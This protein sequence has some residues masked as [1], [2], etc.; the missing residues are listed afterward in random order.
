MQATTCLHDGIANPILQQASLVFH[1]PV[2][3]HPA[4]GMFNT[5]SDGRKTTIGGFLRG[6]ELPSTRC[7]LGVDDRDV[8]QAACLEAPILRQGAA[9]GQG[10]A[11]E[12]CSALI[13]GVAGIGMAQQAHGTALSDH[14]EVFARV[15]LRR[16]PV[17][18]LWLFGIGRALKRT[19]GAI[20]P[21]RGVVELPSVVDVSNMSAHAAAVRA[22]S[23]SW[24]AKA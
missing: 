17:V 7:F 4:H 21:K 16:A 6:G 1:D 20:R 23:R 5:D 14:E 13:R 3:V 15:T 24:S 19:F 9:R 2:A 18:F 11:S 12:L 8:R 10:R 22:G